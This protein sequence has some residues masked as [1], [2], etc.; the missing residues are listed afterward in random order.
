MPLKFVDIR[1]RNCKKWMSLAFLNLSFN[2]QLPDGWIHNAIV[3][4]NLVG[5]SL[6]QLHT[7]T[8]VTRL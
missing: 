5:C 1:A 7:I 2:R 8:T 6:L 4:F 3:M